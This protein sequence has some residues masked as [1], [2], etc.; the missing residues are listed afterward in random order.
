MP[1]K[2][3]STQNWICF[4]HYQLKLATSCKKKKKRAKLKV[5]PSAFLLPPYCSLFPTLIS[6]AFSYP[7]SYSFL[8]SCHFKQENTKKRKKK[9][10]PCKSI[11]VPFFLKGYF[12]QTFML[13]I[14]WKKQRFLQ[15]FHMSH[16]GHACITPPPSNDN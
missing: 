15:S 8:S 16:V 2:H 12:R 5:F 3:Y 4:S 6:R 1:N 7:D 13:V 10:S 9:A 11:Y 14:N